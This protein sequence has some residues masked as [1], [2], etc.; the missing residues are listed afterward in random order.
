MLD[1]GLLQ[2]MQLACLRQAFDGRDLRA[3]LHH[4]QGQ[5][6]IDAPAVEEDGAGAALAVI[7]ALLR[8]GEV[9]MKPQR[10]EQ[11]GPGR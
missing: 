2:R 6:R 5:A 1:E 8:P 9:E 11:R 10:V 3:V 7:A 4:R